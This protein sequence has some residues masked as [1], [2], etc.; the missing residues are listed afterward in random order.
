[1]H[2]FIHC[3]KTVLYIYIYMFFSCNDLKL[4]GDPQEYSKGLTLVFAV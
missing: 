1:M 3:N 4:A 2:N